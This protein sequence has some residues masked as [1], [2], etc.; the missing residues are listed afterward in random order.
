V[1]EEIELARGQRLKQT[2]HEQHEIGARHEPARDV[3]LHPLD[4]VRSRRIHDLEVVEHVERVVVHE[5]VGAQRLRRTRL[6]VAENGDHPRRGQVSHGEH[7]V[8]EQGV[9][10]RALP[11]VVLAHDDE[12]KEL[13]HLVHEGGEALEVCP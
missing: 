10:E 7:L 5:Q 6:A 4:R 9:D 3:F 11:G 8:A 12:Q 1:T 2:G 13:V